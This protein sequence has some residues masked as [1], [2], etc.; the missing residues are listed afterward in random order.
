M[1]EAHVVL[2]SLVTMLSFIAIGIPNKILSTSLFSN[3]IAFLIAF[4]LSSVINAFK[5]ILS[6]INSKHSLTKSIGLIAF[7]FNNS[8]I[9]LILKSKYLLI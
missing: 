8:F 4:S 9:S 5:S 1:C 7:F 2:K 3:S 6:S